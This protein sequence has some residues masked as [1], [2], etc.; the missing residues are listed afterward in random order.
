MEA[1][2]H[3]NAGKV[4][5]TRHPVEDILAIRHWQRHG[6]R[7]RVE[8]AVVDAHSERAVLLLLQHHR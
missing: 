5:R 7:G 4:L 2:C 1:F 3:V 6:P 8:L